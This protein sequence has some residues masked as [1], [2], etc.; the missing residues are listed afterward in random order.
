V[1]R[2][3]IRPSYDDSEE[4]KGVLLDDVIADGPAAKAG[5]KA[6][7]R[8]VEVAGQPVKNLTA[9][10]TTMSTQK[11]TGTLDLVVDRAGKRVPIKVKLD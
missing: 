4:D 7:D 10:M 1:P 8:I 9:Y 6:G 5:I 3:G 2:L 11:K